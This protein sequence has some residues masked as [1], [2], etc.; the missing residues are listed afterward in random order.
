M[1]AMIASVL[2]AAAGCATDE[3]RLVEPGAAA[4]AA[5]AGP[6]YVE[7]QLT[8]TSDAAPPGSASL[9]VSVGRLEI[10]HADGR[11]TTISAEPLRFDAFAAERGNAAVIA[12]AELPAG[13]YRT[14]AIEI[15]SATFVS[16][17]QVL[18]ITIEH[19]GVK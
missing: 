19:G 12:S 2:V 18:P 1:K 14:L 17:G 13:S 11:W 4:P 3:V 16:Q 9:W 5:S 6:A 10:E 8:D 15:D 7:L